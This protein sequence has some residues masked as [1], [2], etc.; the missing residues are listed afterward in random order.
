MPEATNTPLIGPPAVLGREPAFPDGL[1]FVRPSLPDQA[2]LIDAIRR[3]LATRQLT[4]GEFVRELEGRA[5]EFLGVSHCIAVSSCTAGLM[6]VLRAADLSGD[7][8]IPSF[9]FT[10][11]AHAVAWN[12]LRPVFADIDSETLTLSA[13]AAL[14]AT[15]VRA[16]AILATHTFG[17]PCDVEA[18]THVAAHNGIRLFFDSAHAFGSKHQ[19]LPVGGFGDA[20]V[21]SFSPTKVV[22]AGEGG[23]IATNDDELAER[24]RMGRD[25]ANPGNYDC[26]FVGLNARMSE[27][28]AAMALGSM[29]GLE[30]RVRRRNALAARYRAALEGLPGIAFPMVREGDWSTYKDFTMLVEAEGFGLTAQALGAALHAE[31]IQTRRY[32]A[33]PVHR[34]RAYRAL[35]RTNG[36]LPVTENA[37]QRVLTLPLWTEMTESLVDRV[38]TA[39]ERIR[40]YVVGRKSPAQTARKLRAIGDVNEVAGG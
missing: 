26:Q 37:S 27:F 10:A 14:K 16:S 4:N 39:I 6:L 22:V 21:F 30:E 8:I 19:G 1:P 2:N 13:A 35:A 20:E 5:A 23:L 29:D 28:H 12:G 32:Y 40:G 3:I 11:T 34:Q 33:P 25:Y 7:V 38:A 24:C 9:T 18:L 17:T 31:G 36:Y 15:G